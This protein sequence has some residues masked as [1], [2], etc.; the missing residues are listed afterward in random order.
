MKNN[1]KGIGFKNF[2]RFEE[3]PQ[4]EFGNITYMVGRNNSGKSTMVKALL[5]IMDYLQNQL[6]DTFSF[7]NNVLEDANIVTFGRAKC[8]LIDEPKIVFSFKLNNYDITVHISGNANDTKANVILLSV[9]DEENGYELLI[10]YFGEY[11]RIVKKSKL[12]LDDIE[13]LEELAMLGFEINSLRKQQ[14][15]ITNKGSKEALDLAAQINKM[16]DRKE[17]LDKITNNLKLEEENIEYEVEYPM[18]E[19]LMKASYGF[20]KKSNQSESE[21][22]KDIKRS[23]RKEQNQL[24]EIISNLI[25][26]NKDWRI[27]LYQKSNRNIRNMDFAPIVIGKS[28]KCDECDWAWEISSDDNEAYTCKK[29]GNYNQDDP[30]SD[31][32]ALDNKKSELKDWADDL[33]NTL[34]QESYIYLGANPS[35]QSALFPLRSKGNALAQAIHQFYQLNIKE[36]EKEY[37]FVKYWMNKFEVGHNFNIKFYA[38]EAY[39]FYVFDKDGNKNHLSDKGMGSLQAMLL[40]LRVAS[41][42]KINKKEKK[43][44][45][46]LVEEPELNLHPA[47]QSK[48]TDFFHEVNKE[49]G[50]N[51]IVET[52]SEYM[53]RKTQLIAL[54]QDYIKNQDINPNPFKIV[55]FHK[56]EGPY[57]MEFTEQ[58]KFN[59]DFGP[60]FYDEAG[61]LTLKMIKELRKNQAQ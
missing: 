53:I 27:L 58:G 37:E 11:A 46:L 5:L 31:I 32:I 40:I 17:K 39:E 28:V 2:R 12:K 61:S 10:D 48:L 36:G 60:G 34:E 19:D 44:L 26:N 15:T 1:T 51:F 24:K 30:L 6:G 33:V 13:S 21:D 3:F 14:K 29:C 45:T 50:F 38:G 43:A 47:L 16:S 18:G 42:I 54:E 52:H 49:Y 7:D 56:E 23:N 59:K 57:E 20:V 22:L 25:S 8:N 55:Y 41:L 4:L 35:K 9:K